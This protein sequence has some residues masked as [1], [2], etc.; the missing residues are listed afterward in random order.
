MAKNMKISASNTLSVAIRN[1]MED[2]EIATNNT[3]VGEAVLPISYITDIAEEL[4][5]DTRLVLIKSIANSALFQAINIYGDLLVARSQPPSKFD[6]LNVA[7]LENR[8]H[9]QAGI[10]NYFKQDANTEGSSGY[11]E[12]MDFGA[13][14]GFVLAMAPKD[15]TLDD[16]NYDE[17]FLKGIGMTVEKAKE[18]DAEQY[19]KDLATFSTK[20]D[21]LKHNKAACLATIEGVDAAT[22]DLLVEQIYRILQKVDLKIAGEIERLYKYRAKMKRGEAF[23]KM[24]VLQGDL[25][26]IQKA[27]EKLRREYKG[28]SRVRFDD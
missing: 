13:A 10:Y 2:D 15:L 16:D 3:L 24:T 6:E 8:F 17:G 12:P 7:R 23:S 20:T 19:A 5:K 4:F 1:R 22:P 25:P 26:K 27:I 28:D 21:H 11:D 14:F 18:L 9:A